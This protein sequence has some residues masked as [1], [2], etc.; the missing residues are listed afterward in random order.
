MAVYG[1][2]SYTNFT[3]VNLKNTAAI[4]LELDGGFAGTISVKPAPDASRAWTLPDKSGTFPI[5][6]TFAVQLPAIAATTFTQSTIATVSGIRAEDALA[7]WHNTGVSAGYAEVG[8]TSASTS[9][10]LA[11]AYPGNGNITLVF[12]NFGAATGYVEWTFSYLAMR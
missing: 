7:V 8:I 3:G 5:M 12:F 6:G 2:K 1:D 11:R 10:I 4:R 9:R